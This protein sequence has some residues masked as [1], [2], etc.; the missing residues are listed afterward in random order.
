MSHEPAGKG[1]SRTRGIEHVIQGEGGD[2]EDAAVLQ[3]DRAVHTLLDHHHR[4]PMLHDPAGG[5]IDVPVARQLPGLRIVHHQHV[6][7]PHYLQQHVPGTVDPVVHCVAGNQVRLVDL[8]QHAELQLGIDVTQED[9]AGVAE[10]LGDLGLEVGEHPESGL[11]RLPVLQ[12]V[13][14]LPFPA[15]ALTRLPL[16][17]ADVHV[18]L[19]QSR[20]GIERV[21]VTHHGDQLHWVQQPRRVAEEQG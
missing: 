16:D 3:Q 7:A 4:G 1:I 17:A 21:V 6:G 11:Q 10:R 2:V 18:L 12:V 19:S 5:T 20:Q 14:V 8:V 9:V 13:G 15:E